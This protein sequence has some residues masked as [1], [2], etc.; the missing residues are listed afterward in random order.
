LA[1]IFLSYSRADRD[2]AQAV[3]QALRALG[4]EVWWDEDMPGV[5]WQFELVDRITEMA[6]VMVLWSPKSLDSKNVRDEA[7]LAYKQ[8]K[9]INALIGVAEPREPFTAINGM[10]LDGWDGREPHNGWRR[11]VQTAES[12]LVKVG[13]VQ[14]G[15]LVTALDRIEAEWA[16]LKLEHREATEAFSE[17]QVALTEA[18]ENEQNARAAASAAN[19]EL[20]RI[21]QLDINPN[22]L[23]AAI[24]AAQQFSDERATALA[25]AAS[26]VHSA[27]GKLSHASR[28]MKRLEDDMKRPAWAIPQGLI[29]PPPPAPEKAAPA[30]EPTQAAPSKP[31]P[32]PEPPEAAEPMPE[33]TP[34][35]A[36]GAPREQEPPT[37]GN[38]LTISTTSTLGAFAKE[39]RVPLLGLGATVGVLSLVLT[40]ASLGVAPGAIPKADPTAIASGS[41][42]TPGVAPEPSPTATSKATAKPGE[43]LIG[44][45]VIDQAKTGCGDKLNVEA[46][47]KHGFLRFIKPGQ[48][49]KDYRIT[50]IS[51][52][53]LETDDWR[54]SR[55][56]NGKI[57]MQLRRDPKVFLEL[58]KCAGQ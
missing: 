18:L 20:K 50:I 19:S 11:L 49:T 23:R 36:S 2:H 52:E 4:V 33:P 38:D 7:R 43:W 17:A 40:L 15:A 30:P 53:S 14:P 27:R 42:P 34:E 26:A 48:I 29:D 55:Q 24:A 37:P 6:A 44:K 21:A 13:D 58:S 22:T 39:N 25:E 3:V 5:E 8:D 10:P 28:K 12:F 35:P 32:E 46:S 41:G 47:D 16:A 9:L 31:E 54:Y 57:A 45:W 51:K 56:P 1:G